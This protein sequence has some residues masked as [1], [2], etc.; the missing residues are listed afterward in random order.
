MFIDDSHTTTVE[1]G[2]LGSR[3]RRRFETEDGAMFFR[4]Q[5]STDMSLCR[6]P[7]SQLRCR[8]CAAPFRFDTGRFAMA[9][10]GSRRAGP[11][12]R[13]RCGR[14]K[15]RRATSVADVDFSGRGA[16]P[17][18][19]VSTNIVDSPRPHVIDE[20]RLRPRAHVSIGGSRHASR[21]SRASAPSPIASPAQFEPARHR[22]RNI[23][24]LSLS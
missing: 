20:Y 11:P 7:V 1:L 13:P 24:A 6:P 8:Y 22:L 16:R 18:W 10:G 3:R 5:I 9:R 2:A 23:D 14:R 21:R 15:G 17:E 19:R 4:R 12:I